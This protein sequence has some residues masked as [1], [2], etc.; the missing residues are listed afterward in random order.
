MQAPV[1]A[2]LPLSACRQAQASAGM[3][4]LADTADSKS[5]KKLSFNHF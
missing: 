4:E 5:S 3:A 1:K 2:R